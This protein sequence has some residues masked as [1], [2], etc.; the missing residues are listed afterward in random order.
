[1][2][3]RAFLCFSQAY[4]F[5]RVSGVGDWRGR[6]SIKRCRNSERR[7]KKPYPS[8][9]QITPSV[10]VPS[11]TGPADIEVIDRLKAHFA[12]GVREAIDCGRRPV[13]LM[14]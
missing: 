7:N 8:G 13:S 2:T 9:P 12:A 4:S 14:C 10:A 1:M 11:K 5:N 3:G 6:F